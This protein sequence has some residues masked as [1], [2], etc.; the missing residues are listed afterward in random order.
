MQNIA[1]RKLL[2]WEMFTMLIVAYSLEQFGSR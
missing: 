1:L 2:V